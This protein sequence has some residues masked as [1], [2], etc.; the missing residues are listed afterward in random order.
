M[1]MLILVTQFSLVLIGFAQSV[2]ANTEKFSCQYVGAMG[3]QQ[4]INFEEVADDD[5]ILNNLAYFRING[6]ET[7]TEFHV[8]TL[9]THVGAITT[10]TSP[11]KFFINDIT[12]T[13]TEDQL[14]GT[15]V[16]KGTWVVDHPPVLSLSCLAQE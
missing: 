12:L 16:I 3:I 1:K 6:S 9:I 10:Y 15:K 2:Q 4:T 14:S 5:A 7:P 13:I 8:K 11:G